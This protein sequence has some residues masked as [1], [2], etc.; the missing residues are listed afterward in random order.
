MVIKIQCQAPGSQKVPAPLLRPSPALSPGKG[1]PREPPAAD[2]SLSLLLIAPIFAAA[3]TLRAPL[4]T[5]RTARRLGGDGV[6]GGGWIKMI[7]FWRGTD[8][9]KG[10]NG[11]Q[12]Q[13]SSLGERQISPPHDCSA[14]RTISCTRGREWLTW[15]ENRAGGAAECQT[16]EPIVKTFYTRCSSAGTSLLASSRKHSRKSSVVF[17][18]QNGCGAGGDGNRDANA[19]ATSATADGARREPASSPEPGVPVGSGGGNDTDKG[20]I[21]RGRFSTKNCYPFPVQSVPTQNVAERTLPS[22]VPFDWPGTGLSPEQQRSGAPAPQPLR[23]LPQLGGPRPSALGPRHQFPGRKARGQRALLSASGNKCFPLSHGGFPS[24]T[25][26][27]G[28]WATPR[29]PPDHWPGAPAG[30]RP[31]AGLGLLP[32]FRARGELQLAHHCQPCALPQS[33][34]RRRRSAHLLFLVTPAPISFLEGRFSPSQPVPRLLL[35]L[36]PPPPPQPHP[37]PSNRRP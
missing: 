24:G 26:R 21:V 30:R 29:L 23:T 25:E 8:T 20:R 9:F 13:P 33:A 15:E 37:F 22:A 10:L 16:L 34:C 7:D 2:P 6:G 35:A 36:F 3:A 28:A 14:H 11:R 18:T 5:R 4:S 19:D 27:K 12:H 17:L 32:R 31:N 1:S